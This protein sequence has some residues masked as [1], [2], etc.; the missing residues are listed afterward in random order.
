MIIKLHKL[1]HIVKEHIPD[2]G[3]SKKRCI[4]MFS[5]GYLST[6]ATKRQTSKINKNTHVSNSGEGEEMFSTNLIP[7]MG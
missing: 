4:Q 1:S 5:R 3:A 7:S 2:S 6:S